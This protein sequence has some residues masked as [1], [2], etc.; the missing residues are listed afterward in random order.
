MKSLYARMCLIFC[1]MIVVSFGLGFLLSNVYYHVKIKPKNDKK[2]TEMALNIQTFSENNSGSTD[3]YFSHIAAL[4]YRIYVTNNEGDQR[5]YGNPFKNYHLNAEQLQQVLAGEIF[6]G[7]ALYKANL[8]ITGFFDNEIQNSI[9]V[10]IQMNGQTYAM[11]MRPDANVQFG[12]LR[13]FFALLLGLALLLSFLFLMAS[14]LHIVR[15]ITRLTAA[16][17]DI[18]KG[19]YNLQVQSRRRD[20]IGQ[21]GAHFNVMSRELQRTERARQEFVANVSHEIESPLTSIQGFAATLQQ[22]TLDHDQRVRYL[23]IIEEES[24]RL[25]TLSKQLLTLSSLDFGSHA[26]HMKTFNLR[27]QIRQ[28]A[29][30]MEWRLTEQ[31]LSLRLSIP[32]LMLHGDADL[33]Y[34]V[35]TNLLSNAIKHT[36][37]GGQ[38]I[39]TAEIQ[40]EQCTVTVADSGEGI[41]KDELP[42]IFDRFYKVDRVR[43]RES[44]GTGLGLSI[45]QKVVQAHN[46]MIQA[47]NRADGKGAVFT[48]VLPCGNL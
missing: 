38:I 5:F 26:L 3:A 16:T 19:K 24:R 47:A 32:D 27:S 45:V 35:W 4:G 25:S 14:T 39:V 7:V 46:G 13:V 48:V 18:V 11:F 37:A 23:A 9:G 22:Q 43:T 41:S 28:V 34:Q 8:L 36:P 15:P 30:M 6:H 10:P 12:E 20:E 42:Y 2:L 31:E 29:Q 33:L 40:G 1:S 21:L 44:S 17:Q